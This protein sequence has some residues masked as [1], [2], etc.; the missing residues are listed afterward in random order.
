MLIQHDPDEFKTVITGRTCSFHQSNPGKPYAG[1]TCS[2]SYGSVR[3][4]LEEVRAIRAARERSEE[5]RILAKARAI[6]AKRR[7]EHLGKP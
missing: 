1:C 5:D 6:R 4:P 7:R 3:R 2:S